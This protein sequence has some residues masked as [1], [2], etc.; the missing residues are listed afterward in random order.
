MSLFFKIT[1]KNLY[2]KTLNTKLYKEN[3]NLAAKWK[4]QSSN[5]QK[6][7]YDNNLLSLQHSMHLVK[8]SFEKI[9]FIGNNPEIFIQ[10]SPSSKI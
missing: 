5:Y 9:L 4:D 6:V 10:N 2:T 8:K 1:W 7:L 3:K